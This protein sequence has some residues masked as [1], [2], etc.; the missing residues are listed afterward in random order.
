M[1]NSNESMVIKQFGEITETKDG[2]LIFSD[3]HCVG[4]GY[5]SRE[6]T[7]LV[8]CIERLKKELDEVRYR[9]AGIVNSTSHL[10]AAPQPDTASCPRCYGPCIPESCNKPDTVAVDER[11]KF[12]HWIRSN[13]PEANLAMIGP[14]GG[15]YY[16]DD[17]IC[18]AWEVWQARALLDQEK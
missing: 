3:F 8:L 11:A 2:T 14:E 17:D 1:V 5:K 7:I 12:E 4:D 15:Q 13:V 10:E 9:E 16:D 18:D 6:E